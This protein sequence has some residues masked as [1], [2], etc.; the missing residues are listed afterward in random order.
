M[1]D[2][3]KINLCLDKSAGKEMSHPKLKDA[4][5]N[6]KKNK[7]SHVAQKIAKYSKIYKK[8]QSKLT[9]LKCF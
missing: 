2:F 6:I 4:R 5:N 3:E 1:F 7:K 8:H 9:I